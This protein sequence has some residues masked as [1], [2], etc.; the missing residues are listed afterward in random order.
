M[1]E[2]KTQNITESTDLL[3]F[4]WKWRKQ[5]AIIGFSAA[6]ISAIVSFIITPKYESAV[7]LF[8]GNTNSLS[9][10]LFALDPYGK[11]DIMQFGEEEQAEQML[12]LLNSDG[13]RNHIYQEFDLMNHYEIDQDGKYK[14]TELQKEYESNISFKRTPFSSIEIKVL[15]KE[16]QTAADIANAIASQVDSVRYQIS[17][18]RAEKSFEIVKKEYLRFKTELQQ[19]ED[20][21]NMLRNKGVLDYELQVEMLSKQYGAAIVKG[22]PSAI[23]NIKSQLDTLAKYGGKYNSIS[24]SLKFE[25]EEFVQMKAI[26]EKA[27]VDVNEQISQSFIVNHA[28]ASDKKATPIRWLIVAVST[29]GALVLGLV[30][31]LV[32]DRIRFLQQKA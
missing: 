9:K 25:R 14:W 10:A 30:I 8:P 17:R 21:L 18:E 19:K 2:Q 22:N 1:T 11:L 3:L 6:L 29:I 13:I 26:Y 20:T 28:Y 5:L 7:V 24:K 31:L 12:Q 27:K 15:D 4:V 32:S 16:P 23:R